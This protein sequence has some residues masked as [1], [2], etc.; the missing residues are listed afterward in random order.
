MGRNRKNKFEES[1]IVLKDDQTEFELN[2]VKVPFWANVTYKEKIGKYNDGRSIYGET[3]VMIKKDIS[4]KDEVIKE[5]QKDGNREVLNVEE[6]TFRFSDLCPDCNRNGIPK[7]EKKSNE[8]DYHYRVKTETHKTKTNR[9]DEYWLTFDHETKPKKCRIAKWDKNH[10][11][12]TKNG[13]VYNKLRK[14]FFPYFI[15]WKQGELDDFDSFQKFVN[16]IHT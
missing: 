2:Q 5:F 10:L 14:Y 9:R 15:Q 13:K 4:K 6:F 16:T 7:V 8:I 11:T 3:T 12:F 1:Y